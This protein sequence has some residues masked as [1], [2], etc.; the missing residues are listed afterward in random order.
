MPSIRRFVSSW[1]PSAVALTL[2]LAPLAEPAHAQVPE[3]ST[4]STAAGLAL[5]AYSGAVL[6]A[7]AT[8]M[9]CNR[10][11]TGGRC[12]ASGASAGG[13][14][15]V[16][17]GGL[18][19]AQNQDDL[20]E[21]VEH[22]GLGA[23]V[24]GVVGLGLMMGVRQYGWRDVV[25]ASAVGTAVGAASEGAMYGAGAGAVL[26][27]IAWLAIPRAGLPEMLMVTVAGSAVGGIV[28]WARGAA[29]ANRPAEPAFGASFRVPIG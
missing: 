24:G 18:I 17:M 2:A 12:T 25:A 4:A 26:G 5:G 23:A 3:G 7:L 15:G 29:R 6:G 14:I 22:A 1:L 19:G 21:R 28:D 20:R 10:T 27:S 11:I 13:A 16:A 8:M 9:P